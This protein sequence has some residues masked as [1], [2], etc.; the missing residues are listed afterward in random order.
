M[1]AE[2]KQEGFLVFREYDQ[3]RN[4]DLKELLVSRGLPHSGNK[5]SMVMRLKLNDEAQ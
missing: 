3:L 2:H 4:A 1:I 5:E